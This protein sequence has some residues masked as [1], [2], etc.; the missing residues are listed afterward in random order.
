MPAPPENNARQRWRSCLRLTGLLMA[1]G[2]L[3]TFGVSFFARQLD[4]KLFGWPFSFWMAAQGALVVYLVLVC[5]YASAMHRLD[6]RYG[7]AEDD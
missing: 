6:V 3:V 5:L 4:F 2:F 1:V 7:V